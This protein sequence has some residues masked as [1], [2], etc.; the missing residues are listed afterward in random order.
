MGL[1]TQAIPVVV[2]G[3]MQRGLKESLNVIRVNMPTGLIQKSALL[4]SARIVRK[5][6]VNNSRTFLTILAVEMIILKFWSAL[7]NWL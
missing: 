5:V 2:L 1:K 4:G 3:T 7:G 6:L